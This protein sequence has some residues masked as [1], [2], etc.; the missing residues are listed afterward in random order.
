LSNVDTVRAARFS[1]HRQSLRDA[2]ASPG[3]PVAK[4]RPGT[5]AGRLVCGIT[6]GLFVADADKQC[7]AMIAFDEHGLKTTKYY[8]TGA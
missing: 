3:A 1:Q 2:G 5:G 7:A 6:R 8:V 4:S